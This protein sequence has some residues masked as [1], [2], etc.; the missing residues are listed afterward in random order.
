MTGAAGLG[1][2][3][4]RE[5]ARAGA[6]VIMVSRNATTG[7]EAVARILSEMPQASVRFEPLD[8]GSLASVAGFADRLRSQTEGLDLL[9]NN[10][11]VM[12]PQR[13]METQDG[14][15]IQFGTN[16]LGH[17]ALTAH[18]LPLLV[19]AGQARVVTV[20]SIAARGGAID[21]DD[22]QAR[23]GYRPMPVY[24]QSKLACLMFALE[25]QRRSQTQG[26]GIASIAAHP[27]VSRTG[28]L[29]NTP[30]GPG[31]LRRVMRAMLWFM[32]QPVPQGALPQ[33]FA[34]TAPEAQGGGYYG[35]D[36]RAELNGFPAP[37]R[38]PRPAQ[39]AEA[40]VRL[41]RVAQDLTG[42]RFEVR[43]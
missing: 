21:F 42:L 22:L 12:T 33:L 13:R 19:N 9:I 41:W 30:G 25:L 28:L 34:A 35:P 2:E 32:F 15:E 1:F 39:D 24:A 11:G 4:A 14:F 16:Y 38:V 40:C 5:L 26:W 31:G 20:S 18:L 3:T 8:L 36:G 7:A 23:R 27:G 37:A 43:S 17:F 10:A 6:H 29:Y